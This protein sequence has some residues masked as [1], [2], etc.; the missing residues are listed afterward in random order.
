MKRFKVTYRSG[1][2][3]CIVWVL[4]YNP[5]DAKARVIKDYYDC[6]EIIEV[7]FVP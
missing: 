5:V 6:D 2:D 1:E 7:E 4:G 3:E